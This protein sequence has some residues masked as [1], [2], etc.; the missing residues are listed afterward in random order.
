[1]NAAN[2]R[3][4]LAP[5]WPHTVCLCYGVSHTAGSSHVCVSQLRERLQLYAQ[6]SSSS[7]RHCGAVRRNRRSVSFHTYR[8]CHWSAVEIEHA[9]LVLPASPSVT[10]LLQSRSTQTPHA[11]LQLQQPLH[12]KGRLAVRCF[13]YERLIDG[14][15][16]ANPFSDLSPFPVLNNQV[17]TS[18][19]A[20]RIVTP[21]PA[22]ARS[23]DST[24]QHSLLLPHSVTGPASP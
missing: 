12:A 7:T 21:G 10:L 9:W 18:H 15:A 14:P 2:D 20:Q 4:L 5:Q 8:G 3:S 1:M 19:S 22:V 24:F 13:C 17:S 16:C 11:R 23:T 6:Q